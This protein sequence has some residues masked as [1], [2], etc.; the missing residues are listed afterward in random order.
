MQAKNHEKWP[1][2]DRD[3]V[4]SEQS[5]PR[6][7]PDSG[8]LS[9]PYEQNTVLN[10]QTDQTDSAAPRNSDRGL[11]EQIA[12][13]L[14][15]LDSLDERVR[16]FEMARAAPEPAR[17]VQTVP[18]PAEAPRPAESAPLQKPAQAR[19]VPAKQLPQPAPASAKPP[20]LVSRG[21]PVDL[22]KLIG[23]HILAWVGGLSLLLGAVFFLSLAFSRGWIGP[24]ER[25]VIGLAFGTMMILGGAWFFERQQ[26]AFGHVLLAVGLG[27][28]SLSLFAA[29]PQMYDFVPVEAALAGVLISAAVA[30]VVA[31]RANSQVVAAYG[32]I[33]ALAAPPLMGADPTGTTIAY[34]SAILVGT[35]SI[36]LYRTWRWLPALAFLLSAPQLAD[37]VLS[38][39]QLIVALSAIAGFWFLHILAA[40]GEEFRIRRN[41]LSITSTT[42]LVANATFLVWAGF[43][44]LQGEAAAWRGLFLV[45]VALA[46]MSIGGYFLWEEGD[47]HPFGMLAFGTGI[48][49]LTIAI[50][51]QLGGP[52]VP[53]AWAAQA[54][55]LAWVYV[56]RRHGYSGLVAIAL[57]SLS[58]GHLVTIEYP[59]DQIETW[60]GSAYP[61]FNASGGTLA[62]ILGAL[63]VAGY[64]LRGNRSRVTVGT[65]GALLIIYAAPFELSGVWLLTAWSAVFVAVVGLWRSFPQEFEIGAKGAEFPSPLLLPMIISSSLALGH[66]ILVDVPIDAVTWQL[67]EIPFWTRE[68]FAAGVVITASLL[69][70]FI[71]GTTPARRAGVIGAAL[72]AAYLM[73]FQLGDPATVVAWATLALLLG[74]V[75]QWDS[76][77]LSTY[78]P[79]A[80]GL[81]M[82]G[83]GLAVVNVA[84]PGRL[85]VDATSQI[86]HPFLWSGA[87]AALG[88]L[89]IV[90]V[91]GFWMYQQ[92][93][94]AR[95]LA[96]ASAILAVYLISI[97][98]VDQFQSRLGGPT[99]LEE[100]QK[101]AQVALSILWAILGG[102]AFVS[103]VVRDVMSARVFGLSLLALTTAKV[104]LYDMASLDAAYRVLSFI[105]LGILLLLSAY[106]YQ[107]MT[108]GGGGTRKAAA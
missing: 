66:L 26:A 11:D 80:A 29:T 32:L 108:P 101:Q 40:G 104:F 22:E 15:R 28:V 46:H 100:L 86:D 106:A 55:A 83:I 41:R 105:G 35:T 69:A 72:V 84:P 77:G 99:E 18:T 3:G 54:V 1:I 57:T 14:Q 87:T 60:Q 33:A 65:I 48:A 12:M 24:S 50:P 53:I 47:R 88:A 34:V 17:L 51:V 95:W 49:A 96:L 89:A 93:D 7:T 30:T 2:D 8:D 71:A 31:I 76:D 79:A 4:S 98:V 92:H 52:W 56:E 90:L 74:I 45:V 42:L 16:Q 36:A 44:I 37:W 70:G 97:G 23:R 13:I 59:L 67:P 81:L 78:L 10:P 27:I 107:R 38:N 103:G 68:A 63:V 75:S 61:F 82:I 94:T 6:D 64:L 25:V 62:F 91:I 9:C 21:K 85:F 19:T 58:I 5:P 43:E 39:P 20:V 102:T 73:P